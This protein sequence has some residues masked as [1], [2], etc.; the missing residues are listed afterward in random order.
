MARFEVRDTGPGLGA[1]ELQRV[2]EPFVRGGSRATGSGLGLTIGRMLAELMGGALDADSTPGDGSV[3]TVRLYLPAVPAPAAAGRRPASDLSRG[4]GPD[5]TGR[6]VLVVDDMEAERTLMRDLLE[7]RGYI[8][9]TADS[10][11]AALA[12]LADASLPRPDAVLTDLAMPG[13]GGWETVHRLRA[14]GHATLPVAVV[15]ADAFDRAIDADLGI[16]PADI[17]VKPVRLTRLLAWLEDR[18]P[19]REPRIANNAPAIAPGDQDAEPHGATPWP[20]PWPSAATLHALH[21]LATGGHLRRLRERLAEAVAAEPQ[22]AAFLGRLQD[23]AR[24]VQMERL[25][26]SLRLALADEPRTHP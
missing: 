24:D 9:E 1:Q 6:R 4:A 21:A 19:V 26:Q 15:S 3:F 5:G 23:L 14:A 17:H 16:T 13:L 25:Q 11:E 18:L 20:T 7:P 8:V 22:A 12:R 2:F 10:G